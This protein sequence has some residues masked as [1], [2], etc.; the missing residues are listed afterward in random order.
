MYQSPFDLF[1]EKAGI[2][3]A[4]FLDNEVFKAAF[5][6]GVTVDKE[7]L[8][9]AL[10]YDRG[11]YDKGFNDGIMAA[12]DELVRCKDCI[13]SYCH[14][15][16]DFVCGRSGVNVDPDDFCSYGERRSDD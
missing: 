9:R 10:Q 7:E 13:V 16:D 11:Q 3:A 6:V 4:E 14:G 12:A 8:I 15:D 1:M 5:S 2:A